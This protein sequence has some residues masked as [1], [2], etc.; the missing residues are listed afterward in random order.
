MR[1][2]VIPTEYNMEYLSFSHHIPIRSD[3]IHLLSISG[4]ISTSWWA[5]RGGKR[6]AIAV[7]RTTEPVVCC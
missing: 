5:E 7:G 3:D 1:Y 4:N 2:I 6:D